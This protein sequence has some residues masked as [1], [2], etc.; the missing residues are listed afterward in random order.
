MRATE[1]PYSDVVGKPTSTFSPA[2]VSVVGVSEAKHG[3]ESGNEQITRRGGR[4][5]N[6]NDGLDLACC[7]AGAGAMSP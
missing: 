7:L 1:K 5:T 4:P 2:G 3:L 6:E